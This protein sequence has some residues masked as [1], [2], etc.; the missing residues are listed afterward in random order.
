MTSE[1][2][3]WLPPGSDIEA[4][5]AGDHWDAIR[6]TA[7]VAPQVLAALGERTGAVFGDRWTGIAYWLVPAGTADDW[8]APHSIALGAACW[9][10][11]PGP[12]AD[13]SHHWLRTVEEHGVLTGP[14]LLADALA[15]VQVP[16]IDHI[17]DQR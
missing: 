1:L 17:G 6:V 4:L 14:R 9:V 11:V 2:P 5:R 3:S 16:T 15:S 13:N 7:D 10:T 8:K 12:K